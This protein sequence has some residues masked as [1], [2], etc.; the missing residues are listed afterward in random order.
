MECQDVRQLLAF[1]ERKSEELDAAERD[2]VQKHLDACPDCP[3]SP[4]R[5]LAV[6]T[7]RS[8][9]S[10]S[11]VA[12]PAGLEAAGAQSPRRRA[13]RC[14][15]PWERLGR[16]GG[17]VARGFG[18]SSV[19]F[20]R[21]KPVLTIDDVNASVGV[22]ANVAEWDKETVERPHLEQHGLVVRAPDKFKYRFLQQVD[23]VEIHGRSVA[24]L[25][26]LRD[27]DQRT[28]A[29]VFIVGSTQFS[30]VDELKDPTAIEVRVGENQQ[31]GFTYVIYHSGDLR[32]LEN[33]F[34]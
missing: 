8:A 30:G 14:S 29:W 11:D 25:A 26:F 23:I 18:G 3:H 32:W 9:S 15:V 22:I 13:A 20:F 6:P 24:R 33:D 17:R 28:S 2:A 31:A 16:C 4:S 34:N 19:A 5:G 21:P 1:L 10:C 12:V 7:R 27:D